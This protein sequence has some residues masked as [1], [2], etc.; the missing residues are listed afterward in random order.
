VAS[1]VKTLAEAV[2][3]AM[4]EAGSGTFSRDFT[5][6]F[7][8]DPKLEEITSSELIVVVSLGTSEFTAEARS[9][10]RVNDNILVSMVRA[11]GDATS[12]L[13]E[14]KIDEMIELAEEIRFFFR[15]KNIHESDCTGAVYLGG[16][17][18]MRGDFDTRMYRNTLQLT[19][20]NYRGVA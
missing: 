11:V 16:E 12:G 8:F 13:D 9:Q 2:V 17:S 14:N 6:Y 4:N 15:Q 19:F 5:A 18:V 3:T 1:Y 20:T 10:D 7:D